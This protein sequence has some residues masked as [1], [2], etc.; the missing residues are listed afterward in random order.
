MMNE[1]KY[2]IFYYPNSSMMDYYSMIDTMVMN[3]SA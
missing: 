1:N 2:R 3:K